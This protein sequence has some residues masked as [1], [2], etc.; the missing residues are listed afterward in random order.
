MQQTGGTDAEAVD[1]EFDSRMTP[2]LIADD[3]M[4]WDDP[5]ELI[6]IIEETDGMKV[7]KPI[8]LS[9]PVKI[10]I[11]HK[12]PLKE[13]LPASTDPLQRVINYE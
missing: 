6:S 1:S 10:P 13:P 2:P 7:D 11:F 3:I 9:K 8:S 5:P 12:S 4:Q